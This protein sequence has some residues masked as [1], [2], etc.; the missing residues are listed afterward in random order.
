MAK[1]TGLNGP[2]KWIITLV[3]AM[4]GVVYASGRQT[5]KI[6]EMAKAIDRKADS[7]EVRR[8]D[9]NVALIRADL[10]EIR[11]MMEDK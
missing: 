7:A 2:A 9:E 4:A 6:E 5:Q 3:V 11:K 1:S 8:I 10:R